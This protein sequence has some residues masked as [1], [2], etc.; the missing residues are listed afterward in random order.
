MDDNWSERARRLEET[1]SVI[2]R[3]D[4]RNNPSAEDIA[5][6]HEAH[7]RHERSFGREDN[8]LAAEERARRARARNH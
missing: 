8:A 1:R 4:P 5:R 2:R 3:A 6:L 7:A